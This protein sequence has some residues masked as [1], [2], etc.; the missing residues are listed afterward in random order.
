METNTDKAIEETLD[1]ARS[2]HATLLRLVLDK[3]AA[4]AASAAKAAA[5]VRAAIQAGAAERE[6]E[7]AE[8]SVLTSEL[9]AMEQHQ[10]LSSLLARLLEHTGTATDA[11]AHLATLVAARAPE[12]EAF[13]KEAAAELAVLLTARVSSQEPPIAAL[14]SAPDASGLSFAGSESKQC[15]TA[16]AGDEGSSDGT[17]ARKASPTGDGPEEA[18]ALQCELAAARARAAQAQADAVATAGQLAEAR[19]TLFESQ[20]WS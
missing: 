16:A 10:V 6:R 4:Q 5:L 19:A 13:T 20:A 1:Q 7:R 11:E 14:R 9:H 12:Q 3:R 17:R 18:A 2:C 15:D 8:R